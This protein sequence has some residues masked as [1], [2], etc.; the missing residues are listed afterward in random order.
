MALPQYQE[1]MLVFFELAFQQT[2][3][4]AADFVDLIPNNGIGVGVAIP[5]LVQ[6]IRESF[7]RTALAIVASGRPLT[8]A[9][10][11]KKVMMTPALMELYAFLD[12][13]HVD[14]NGKVSDAFAQ[15]NP[16]LKLYFGTAAGP[17]P[18]AQSLDPT[19]PSY[20]H[21]YS[22]DIA[23][24]VYPVAECNVNPIVFSANA[25]TLHLLLYGVVDNHKTSATSGNCGERPL[26]TASVQM[27]AADFTDWRLVAIR[28][29]ASGEATSTFYDLIA[30][31]TA[32]EL[33]L[34]TPHP[35]FF[36]T[37]AFFANWSTNQ[38]NQMRVTLNQA[39]IVSTGMAIDGSDTTIPSSA[40]GLDAAHVQS[41]DGCLGCHQLLDPTRSILS[42]TFT[43]GYSSQ[44]DASLVAQKGLFAFQG[45]VAPV[46]TID[47]FA[48]T[49]AQH[50][51]VA[52]AWA[53]KLC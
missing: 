35:G 10:T 43:W 2:Q 6:N 28:P 3:I 34:R 45:V 33:V 49:L 13:R 14:D 29:P 47:D 5:G 8:D 19:S 26:S 16:T 38:S 52:A 22:P 23:S 48:T 12:A 50:P 42:S 41:G 17:I 15:K 4:T 51:L 36:T 20:M 18:L 30:L 24:V 25:Y 53:Q 27:S 39:L 7:A 21:W 1:K 44:T 31:R 40:P 9:F 11:T 37:P 32:S 46:A